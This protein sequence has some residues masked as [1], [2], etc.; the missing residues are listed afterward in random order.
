MVE[1]A[2]G[3]AA[4]VPSRGATVFVGRRAE[5]ERLEAVWAAVEDDRRQVVFVNG[6]P[7]VGKTRLVAETAAAL[8]QHGA[9]VLWAA[10]HEDLDIP[11]RP[12][13]TILEQALDQLSPEALR[14]IPDPK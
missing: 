14:E 8:R 13:V 6:E 2:P 11:Y 1:A 10:C 3:S 9:R 7:G 12:F 4:T 5:F